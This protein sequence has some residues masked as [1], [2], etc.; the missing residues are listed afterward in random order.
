MRPLQDY[1]I[2]K[3]IGES[4]SWSFAKSKIAGINGV[5][6]VEYNDETKVLTLSILPDET[7]GRILND[8]EYI[9]GGTINDSSSTAL[10]AI[11]MEQ[12]V[13]TSRVD[14][15]STEHHVTGCAEVSRLII[16]KISTEGEDSAVDSF[17]VNIEDNEIT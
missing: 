12:Q 3:V 17:D 2:G 8:V 4:Y 7:V 15:S 9:I 11:P 16:N 5:V 14:D 10:M 6:D 1:V 13:V